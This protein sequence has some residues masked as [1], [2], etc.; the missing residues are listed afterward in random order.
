MRTLTQLITIAIVS[1]ALTVALAVGTAAGVHGLLETPLAWW[2]PS[3]LTTC[4]ATLGAS[5]G[6]LG[7]AWHL[8]SALLALAATPVR[9]AREGSAAQEI[10][11]RWGAPAVRRVT[12]GALVAGLTASPALAAD[13]DPGTDDLGWRPTTSQE[14]PAAEAPADD[15]GGSDPA[16][17]EDE[18]GTSGDD[19]S[20]GGSPSPSEH[21]VTAGESLWSITADALG[22]GAQDAAIAEAWP[23]VYA[24]NTPVVGSDPDLIHP[25]TPLTMPALEDDGAAR[26]GSA[27]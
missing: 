12:A 2:G 6:A 1:A 5:A 23:Q 26:P 11:W 22:P 16:A 10:L 18:A 9:G 14:T 17:G 27:R 4:L 24:A 7:A 21:V 13:S 20:R 19:P 15:P 3:Q 8:L 25:G